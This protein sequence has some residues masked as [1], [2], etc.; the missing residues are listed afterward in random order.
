MNTTHPIRRRA[1][2]ALLAASA[3][4][5][6][7]CSTGTSTNAVPE[8]PLASLEHY[9]LAGLDAPQ[10]IDKLDTMPV[11]DRP[12][13]LIASVQPTELVLTSGDGSSE[14]IPVP[15]G[16]FYLSVAPYYT[17]THPCLFHSLTTC[18]GE[19]ANEQVHVTVTDTATR[20][21]L[22]R[23]RAPP[24]TTASSGCGYREISRPS[25]LSTTRAGRP[26]LR[27]PPGNRTSPA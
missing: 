13:D 15:E 12:E 19:M 6:T 27:S 24:M 21:T 17:S 4:T 26:L 5:I 16:E 18:L 11:V 8:S 25:S 3:L 7:G 20:D 9:E 14:T 1:A 10:I 23:N 22:S 2:I